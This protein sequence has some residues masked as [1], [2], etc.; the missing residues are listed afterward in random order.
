[1]GSGATEGWTGLAHF[2]GMVDDIG[3]WNREL[4]DSEVE[5]LYNGGLAGQD[6][7]LNLSPLPLVLT[8]SHSAEGILLS[9]PQDVGAVTLQA[10]GTLANSP[11]EDVATTPILEGGLQK[12][13]VQATNTA[14]FYRLRR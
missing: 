13:T 14:Q 3:L 4:S 2:D 7:N 8:L 5:A 11:W 6:L 10:T 12:V 1:L 9:W